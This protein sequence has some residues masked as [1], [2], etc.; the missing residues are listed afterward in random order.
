MNVLTVKAHTEGKIEVFGGDQFRPLIHVKD[1]ART[2][3][4][5]LYTPV[6]GVF[7]LHKQNVRIKDLAYQ[8]RNHFPDLE[9]KQTELPYQDT[10]NYRVSSE[11]ARSS[12]KFNPTHSID[13]GIEELKYLV[14]TKRIKDL[15][16]ARYSNQAFLKETNYGK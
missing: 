3:V 12:L 4:D 7:N 14:K 9:I 11:K 8:V 6:Q 5:N 16:N 15:N 10:R 1:V 2:V 13:A